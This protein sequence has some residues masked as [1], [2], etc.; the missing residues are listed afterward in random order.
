MHGMSKHQGV[1]MV[2]ST[3]Y[4]SNIIKITKINYDIKRASL[5]SQ[6]VFIRVLYPISFPGFLILPLPGAS[7][8][9]SIAPGGGK[10]RDPGNEVGFSIYFFVVA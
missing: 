6:L 8:L 3:V 4:I 5:I 2:Q 7:D 9:T 10:M 1:A